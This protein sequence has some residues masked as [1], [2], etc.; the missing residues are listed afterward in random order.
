V[1]VAGGLSMAAYRAQEM[2]LDCMQIFAGSPRRYEIKIPEEKEVDNYK[3]K[4]KGID[5]V[6]VHAS[7][8]VNLA[9]ENKELRE[10]SVTSIV[11]SLRFAGTI[12]AKG[13][14]Y[15][16]GSPK[17][18]DKGKAI[19]REIEGLKEV[20][21]SFNGKELLLIE[22]TAG[23]K[24]IGTCAKEVSTI[25]NGLEDI[26][27]IGVCIDTAHAFASGDIK[28][29]SEKE[30]KKWIKHWDDEVGLS[31]IIALHI[32]DSMTK[33]G[34][35]KDRHENIGEGFIGKEGFFVLAKEDFFLNIPW[36]LEVPGIKGDGPDKENVERIRSI[37][38]F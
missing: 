20:F 23:E 32:N 25:I 16:P 17:G 31:R 24:K 5:P 4:I 2:N 13:V 10:K 21:R 33:S 35:Q 1:S 30:I 29:F 9:S 18:G 14:I 6:F 27:N 22:N 38:D 26:V 34:S 19:E 37:F 3:E 11:D 7:Y 28:E 12:G 36:I 8:L 15:H